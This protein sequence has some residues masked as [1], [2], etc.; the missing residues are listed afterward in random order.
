MQT[1]HRMCYF[2]SDPI[3]SNR[4]FTKINIFPPVDTVISKFA[5]TDRQRP[6]RNISRQTLFIR[7]YTT[8][9]RRLR[10][11]RGFRRKD[12]RVGLITLRPSAPLIIQ[13]C[14]TWLHQ[15]LRVSP[16]STPYIPPRVTILGSVWLHTS[17]FP[18][19]TLDSLIVPINRSNGKARQALGTLLLSM[20]H[21]C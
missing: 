13:T 1:I 4:G 21:F 16:T 14:H 20:E 19:L 18:S 11:M 15:S 12:I 3:D 7:L 6:W 5:H 8:E 9:T 10:P 17:V 2:Q